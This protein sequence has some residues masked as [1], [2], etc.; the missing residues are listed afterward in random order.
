MYLI[1]KETQHSLLIKTFFSF[2]KFDLKNRIT[3]LK[4]FKL[5]KNESRQIEN[6]TT[7]LLLYLLKI[8]NINY[9]IKSKTINKN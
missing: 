7:S 1:K 4:I 2:N 9:I 6:Q 5:K 3:K 8:E